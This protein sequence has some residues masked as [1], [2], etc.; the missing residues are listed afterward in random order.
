MGFK[1]RI[2]FDPV[3]SD[4]LMVGLKFTSFVGLSL[5]VEPQCGVPHSPPLFNDWP[6][7][8]K[9]SD[10]FLLRLTPAPV[11]VSGRVE[12][13]MILLLNML[14]EFCVTMPFIASMLNALYASPG[15]VEEPFFFCDFELIDLGCLID[16]E[17]KEHKAKRGFLYSC[18]WEEKGSNSSMHVNFSQH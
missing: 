5:S 10:F 11:P 18:S 3:G 7:P 8:N 13:F 15:K 14:F 4:P 16:C 17:L 6:G 12:K 2:R 1:G 9:R